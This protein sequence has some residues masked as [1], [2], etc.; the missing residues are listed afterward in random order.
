MTKFP[1][2]FFSQCFFFFSDFTSLRELGRNKG[3]NGYQKSQKWL[4]RLCHVRLYFALEWDLE[5][6][7]RLEIWLAVKGEL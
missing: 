1:V 7:E 2:V 4:S 5:I 3:R 6:S